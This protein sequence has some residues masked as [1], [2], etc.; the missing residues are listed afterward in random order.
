M[1]TAPAGQRSWKCPECGREVFL[2]ISQLDPMACDA[3]LT[4]LRGAKGSTP[5]AMPAVSPMGFWGSLGESTKLAAVAIALVVGLV[6]GYVAGSKS[7]SPPAA[8]PHH[9][10][11]RSKESAPADE[12]TPHEEPSNDSETEKRPDAPGPGYH[13]VKGRKRK[14]GTYGTGHWAKDPHSSEAKDSQ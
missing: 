14:D 3:C 9:S 6:I 11:A 13:W 2:P 8:A 7:A 5:S 1:P 12:P 10:P 4:K